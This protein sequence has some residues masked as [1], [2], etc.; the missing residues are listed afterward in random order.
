M[1]YQALRLTNYLKN[2]QNG[3]NMLLICGQMTVQAFLNGYEN[4]Y[5]SECKIRSRDQNTRLGVLHL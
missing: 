2:T 5:C 1:N 3:S 4:M